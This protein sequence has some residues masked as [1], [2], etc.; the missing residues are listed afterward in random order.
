MTIERINTNLNNNNNIIPT[1]PPIIPR[2]WGRLLPSISNNVF[3]FNDNND[4]DDDDDDDRELLSNLEG[5]NDY[6]LTQLR[7]KLD[8]DKKEL[9]ELRLYKKNFSKMINNIPN[10]V[11]KDI[12]KNNK[13]SICLEENYTF[14]KDY[15]ITSC[16][17]VF[18]EECLK[19]SFRF[20]IKCPICRGSLEN[21]FYKKFQI[22][23]INK[24]TGFF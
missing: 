19:N 13:C 7:E 22:E 4:D 23:I 10:Y 14:E 24:Q 20:N 6:V 16:F 9:K 1:R 17:H 11:S 8:K 12:V 5:N 2:R 21:T 3:D 15:I 18:H